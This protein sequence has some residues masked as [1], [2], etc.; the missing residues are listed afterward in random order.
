MQPLKPIELVR[1]RAFERSA[2][3][4]EAHIGKALLFS[5]KPKLHEHLATLIEGDGLAIECG[6]HKGASINRMAKLRPDRTFHG[7]DSFEGLSE[8]WAGNHHRAGHFSLEGQLPEVEPNVR[9]VKGWIDDTLAPF[10]DENP[11]TIDFLHVDTDTYAPAHTILS[12]ARPRL[13]PGSIVLFDELYGYP[14]WEQHEYRA[15]Q[16]TLPEECYE[17]IGFSQME[18]AIRITAVPGAA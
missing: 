9:L 2:A 8:D 10:L 15:L 17:F 18:A 4:I 13:A 14:A 5:R 16:E 6:V 7:F 1:Q 12:A 3:F 11:G